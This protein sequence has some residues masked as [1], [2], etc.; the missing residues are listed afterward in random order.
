MFASDEG[1]RGHAGMETLETG[2]LIG[3]VFRILFANFLPFMFL[4]AILSTPSL[5]LS[6]Y[7]ALEFQQGVAHPYMNLLSIPMS[8]VVYIATGAITYGVFQQLRGTGASF[9]G[10]CAVGARRILPVLGVSILVGLAIFGGTLLLIVPG[11]I[12]A[13]TLYV[14]VPCTVVEEAGVVTS[15]RR[16]RELTRGYRG[17]LFGLTIVLALVQL[18]IGVPL[19]IVYSG[20]AANLSYVGLQWV[21]GVFNTS[22]SATA[23]ALVYFRLRVL[24]ER[25]DV[26]GIA[27]VFA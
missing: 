22:L 12:A 24:K 21:M 19:M 27:A 9:L 8:V 6:L 4:A 26:E 14:A 25:F 10:C 23:M 2:K 5:G 18:A 17:Q 16:S 3:Q 1:F 15:L 20:D 13:L 7:L 11:I